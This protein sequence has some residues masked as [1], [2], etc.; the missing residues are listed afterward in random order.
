MT[1]SRRAAARA[2]WSALVVD[3]VLAAATVALYAMARGDQVLQILLTTLALGSVGALVV[4][5]QPGNAVGWIFCAAGV[6]AAIDNFANEYAVQALL[7]PAGRLPLGLQAGWLGD[8]LWIPL[9]LLAGPWLLALFPDGRVSAPRWRPLIW[10]SA[11]AAAVGSLGFA[12]TPGGLSNAQQ[13]L[14]DFANPVALGGAAGSVATVV[15]PAGLGVVL[16]TA[17]AGAASM[18]QRFRRA[19]PD[20]RQQIK[21][22]AYGG[23]LLAVCVVAGSALWPVTPVARAIVP[24]GLC[25]APVTAGI[26][27]LRYR[28]YD[29]DVVISRTLM[30]G[31]LAGFVSAVYVAIVV[32][33]G[34]LVGQGTHPNLGLSILATAVVAVAFQPVRTRAQQFANRLVYGQRATPYEVLSQLAHRVGDTVAAQDLAPRMARILAEGTGATHT[35]V[36]LTVGDQLVCEASWPAEGAVPAAVEL[37]GA[38]QLAALPAASLVLPV[39]HQGELLGA[40]TLTKP[41]AER[42]TPTEEKLARDV[43]SQAGLVMRN[44]RLTEDLLLKVAELQASRQR[45]VAAQ[46]EERRRLER[47]LHDGAQQQLVA[48]AVKVRLARA[49]STKDAGKA[50]AMLAQVEEDA[51]QA[52][53]DLRDLARGI[54]PPLLAESGLSVALA[55]QARRAALPLR[56]DADGIGRYSQEVEAAVYFCVLE[57]LQNVA[58]YA[59]AGTVTLRVREREGRLSFEVVDDGTGFDLATR[60]LGMGLQGMSDRLSALGGELSVRSAVGQGTTVLGSIPVPG[61]AAPAVAERRP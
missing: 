16:L 14:G 31:A 30:F 21:W 23:T 48:L 52:L 58:K 26:G 10:V 17:G 32:G 24:L 47:N 22:F 33:I 12:L 28:L 27:I 45:L 15:G 19:G 51:S 37:R 36:W 54:Y 18:A 13:A 25:I 40:L 11:A 50:D 56:I 1:R 42:L 9:L 35:N 49:L 4:S 60:R 2:G 34:T 46:D 5:R 39:H 53:Q 41:P 3:C 43:A 44:M 61:D 57:A 38:D 6:V 29:I 20:Q 59:Q 7:H 55:A 8:W